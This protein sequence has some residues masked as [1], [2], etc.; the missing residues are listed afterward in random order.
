VEHDRTEEVRHDQA[1]TVANNEALEVTELSTHLARTLL[2]EGTVS[3]TLRVGKSS[4]LLDAEGITIKTERLLVSGRTVHDIRG[5][6]TNLNCAPPVQPK[7]P[8][9]D[10]WIDLVYLFNDT[11]PVAGA[12]YEVLSPKGALLAKGTLDGEGRAVQVKLPAE[13]STVA[14]SFAR[15]PKKWVLFRKAKPHGLTAQGSAAEHAL[16][17]ALLTDLPDE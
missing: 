10:N 6:K 16:S 1:L 5:G 15:D 11:T 8:E 4:I 12:L 9:G 7:L 17:L 14:V 2:L 3:V 13:H